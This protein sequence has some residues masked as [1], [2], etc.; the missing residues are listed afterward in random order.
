MPA[1]VAGKPTTASVR[2]CQPYGTPPN[3]DACMSPTVSLVSP[4]IVVALVAAIVGAFIAS[5]VLRRGSDA[6][7]ASDAQRHAAALASVK[8]DHARSLDETRASSERYFGE[9]HAQRSAAEIDRD[10]AH[11]QRAAIFAELAVTRQAEADA[12]AQLAHTRDQFA[13]DAFELFDQHIARRSKRPP[14]KRSKPRTTRCSR[15]RTFRERRIGQRRCAASNRS[16]PRSRK[17]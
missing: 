15:V 9:I 8:A 2:A 16:R 17:N 1:Q 13:L 14:R 11:E 4:F 7:R 10:R 5:L 6:L 3:D 12:R